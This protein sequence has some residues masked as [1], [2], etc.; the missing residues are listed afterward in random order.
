[1]QFVVDEGK[2]CIVA[3]CAEESQPADTARTIIARKLMRLIPITDL[4]VGR[5][6]K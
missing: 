5:F 3:L 1:L 6:T 4:A 2:I